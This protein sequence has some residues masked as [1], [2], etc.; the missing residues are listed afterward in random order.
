M[1]GI[2]TKLMSV[3]VCMAMMAPLAEAQHRPGSNGGRTSRPT[4]QTRPQGNHSRPANSGSRPGTGNSSRP[5]NNGQGTRPGNGNNHRPG[6]GNGNNRPNSGNHGTRPGSGN[7]HRPGNNDNHRP[8]NG[9][10]RPGGNGG[11]RPDP[12]RP[13]GVRPGFN[14]NN[15]PGNGHGPNEGH[16]PGH[17]SGH[18]PGH[19]MGHRPGHSH[20]PPYVAPPSRP[21]RPSGFRGPFSRPLPPPPGWRPR[22]GIPVINGILGLTFGSGIS[23]SLDYLFNNGYTVD[24]YGNDMIYLRNVPALNYIWTDATLYYGNGG[25]FD[26]SSFYYSTPYYDLGRYNAVYN[27]LVGTYGMPVAVNNGAGTLLSTWYGGNNGFIT[28]RFNA[29]A[30]VGGSVRYFTTL[31]FGN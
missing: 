21:Y 10:H 6:T 22:P 7:N 19:N 13:D 25:G 11:H 31:S 30:T 2:L 3:V 1:K 5:N 12:G 18:R 28:L 26:G 23:I 14:H 4:Q 8:G 27:T 16:R 15:R 24:G 9:N 20:R 29:Q 17:N